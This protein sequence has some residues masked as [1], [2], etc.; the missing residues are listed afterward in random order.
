MAYSIAND[1]DQ[2]VGSEQLPI[3]VVANNLFLCVRKG[4]G[5]LRVNTINTIQL[6]V[7]LLS[8][9]S[10]SYSNIIIVLLLFLL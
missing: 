3:L 4:T 6:L 9:L 2:I 10:D 5:V 7:T 8:P 1:K